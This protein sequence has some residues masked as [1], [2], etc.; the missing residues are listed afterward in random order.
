[1]ERHSPSTAEHR[2]LKR[3]ATPQRTYPQSGMLWVPRSATL[4]RKKYAIRDTKRCGHC[5]N[6]ILD[7]RPLSA[8]CHVRL[9]HYLS[10]YHVGLTCLGDPG[11]HVAE[12]VI[13]TQRE[14]EGFPRVQA[15][16]ICIHKA[17]KSRKIQRCK[18]L[19]RCK[20]VV[21]LPRAS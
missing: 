15:W 21:Q 14:V 3:Q 12:L 6:S 1:M 18:L 10:T 5:Q 4:E 9:N 8:C 7:D 16:K 17:N 11:S 19:C 2:C 20:H 13:I